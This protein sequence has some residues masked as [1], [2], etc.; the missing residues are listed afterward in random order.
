[1]EGAEKLTQKL[2][3]MHF[4]AQRPFQAPAPAP[5]APHR[6][7]VDRENSN[8]VFSPAHALGRWRWSLE[9]VGGVWGVGGV[10]GVGVVL[11]GAVNP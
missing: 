10:V 11:A 8:F 5:P 2:N 4:S 3:Y 7:L 9:G 1:M 6:L